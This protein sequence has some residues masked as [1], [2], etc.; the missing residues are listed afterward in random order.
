MLLRKYELYFDIGTD[1][2]GNRF[3]LEVVVTSIRVSFTKVTFW[4][5]SIQR[6]ATE[7]P[8]A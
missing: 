5:R 2:T 8:A 6:V 1:G 3:G 7:S 4:P